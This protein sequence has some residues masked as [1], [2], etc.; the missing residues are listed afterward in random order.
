M[1]INRVYHSWLRRLNQLQPQAHQR[2]LSNVACLIAGI[3][4][5]QSVHLSSI[6]RKL[7]GR[8]KLTSSVQRLRRLL[9]NRAIQVRVWY[10]PVAEMLLQ[11]QVQWGPIHLLVDATK[12]GFRH[13]L[14]IVTLAYRRRA[15]PIAWTWIR[16]ARGH[17]SSAKQLALLGYVHSLIPEGASVSLVGDSEFG[18]ID[19]L[20]QLDAWDWLY[21]LRQKGSHLVQQA[22]GEWQ[23]FDSLVTN[24]GDSQWLTDARL[25]QLH[26]YPVNLLA[27]WERGE[28]EPWLLATNHTTPW[29]TLRD[30]A[31]RAWTEEMFGD[32]KRHGVDL[33]ST[34]L[35]H[36]DR[37]SRLTLAVALLYVWMVAFGSLTIKRGRR[38]LVDRNE[39][40]DLSIFR[41]GFY[42]IE[43]ALA[44]HKPLEL[45]LE[46]YF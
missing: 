15:L 38:H 23:R 24:P 26:A 37:L 25:T 45:R 34:H 8:A 22:Q 18:A 30:Y 1:P 4:M 29:L 3:Y 7:P 31:R 17:S 36:F 13:Q 33:E 20:R 9:M 2:R 35:R 28:T 46:P 21:G 44:N 10:R 19:V 12:V 32:M 11:R 27:H 6:A 5:S 41:I 16:C 40:R 39:R 42:T 43:R 14:L